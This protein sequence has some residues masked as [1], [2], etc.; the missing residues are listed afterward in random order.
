MAFDGISKVFSLF[1]QF[2]MLHFDDPI[3]GLSS[4]QILPIVGMTELVIAYFC[5][6]TNKRTLSLGLIG[7][8]STNVIV[9]VIG[10]W[11]MGCHL[12]YGWINPHTFPGNPSPFMVDCLIAATSAM[13]IAGSVTALWVEH[14]VTR[15]A[16]FQK[17]SCPACG[18]HIKFDFRNLGQ[19]IPCPHCCKIIV[20][21][22]PEN[23]KM[24]CFFCQEHIEFPAHAIGEKMPCPHCNKD[25]TL[26]LPV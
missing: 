16:R 3:L 6:F 5:L 2:Q 19:N 14:K 1:E 23:L 24:S 8:L 11:S 21:R 13:L 15:A 9:Y 12:S 4:R 20:L 7:W 10:L 25:I 18:V 17:M 26:K 22:K